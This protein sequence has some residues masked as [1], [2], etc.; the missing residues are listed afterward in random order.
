MPTQSMAREYGP[1]G[2]HVADAVIDGGILGDRLRNA[3]PAM[4]EAHGSDG[5]SGYEAIAENY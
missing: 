1:K 3:A 4:V 5:L 2:N